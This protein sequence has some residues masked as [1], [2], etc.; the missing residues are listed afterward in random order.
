MN[1]IIKISLLSIIFLYSSCDEIMPE[2]AD[3]IIPETSKVVLLEELTGASCPNCPKGTAA[4]EAIIAKFPG[5]VAAVA[6]HGAFLAQPTS[7]SK[8]DFRNPKAAALENWMKPWIGK[9]AAAVNR[10][11]LQ[12]V[13]EK[14]A[15]V[16]TGIWQSKVEEELQT[17]L[18]LSLFFN[19]KY[20]KTS[21]EVDIDLTGVPLEN[22]P[23]NYNVTIYLTES[24]VIDAQT[25]VSVV[26]ED[27]EHNHV[28]RDII[29]K[30]DGDAFGTDLQK[31]K[32]IKKNYK[33]TLPSSPAGLW[34][35]E[36]MEVVVAI[37]H[38]DTENKSVL[39][40]AYKHIIE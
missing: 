7:K 14:Y 2:I 3:P 6:I 30:F 5:K 26:I 21:R 25:N 1:N 33:Y 29:T 15:T 13:D 4:V 24:H 18:Q 17:P 39:Q 36:N 23:G 8:F 32:P 12:N 38:S 9:P 40:A 35:P 28:L 19:V 27:Y 20:D 10:I 16:S 11:D 37:H 34:I 22:L 31:D